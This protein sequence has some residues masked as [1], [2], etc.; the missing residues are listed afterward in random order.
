MKV[1]INR[2]E[3]VQNKGIVKIPRQLS[4]YKLSEQQ[5]TQISN[6]LLDSLTKTEKK[7]K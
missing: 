7:A 2:D 6:I 3:L 5:T 1:K 4:K